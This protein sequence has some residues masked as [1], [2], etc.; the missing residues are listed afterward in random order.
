MRTDAPLVFVLVVNWNGLRH[1]KN[2]IPSLRNSASTRVRHIVLDNGSTDGSVSWL[3][4]HH[5]EV[6]L[7][8]LQRNLGFAEA[9]NIGLRMA[10]SRGADYVALLNNDTRVEPDWLGELLEVAEK[11]PMTAICHAQQRTWDGKWR[12]GYSFIPHW[13]EVQTAHIPVQGPLSPTPSAFASGS[14]MLLRCSTLQRIGFFDE[15]YFAYAEDVDLSLR[16]WTAGYKAMFVPRSIIYHHSLSSSTNEQR[17]FWGY[18]NQLTTLIKNYQL[19]TL[20]RFARAICDRWLVTRN[21]TAL[22]GT[23][24]ALAMLPGTLVRRTRIQQLRSRPDDHLWELPD[25]TGQ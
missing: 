8:T 20:Q 25:V 21:R 6:E 24:S 4:G 10:V 17:M 1:L 2:C 11:D 9:N 3:R 19:H 23:I 22:R 15:R 18:R 7:I 5:P 13:A 16:I 14:A 12:Y